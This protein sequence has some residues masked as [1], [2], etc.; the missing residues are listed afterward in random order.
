MSEFPSVQARSMQAIEQI[1]S[2]Q[3]FKARANPLVYILVSH[4]EDVTEYV[5]SYLMEHPQARTPI[6][7]NWYEIVNK[8]NDAWYLRNT[9][10]RFLFTRDLFDYQLPLDQDLYFFGRTQVVSELIDFVKKSENRGLFGLRKTGKTSILYKV[11]R[12]CNENN[13]AHVLYYDCKRYDIRSKRWIGLLG[14]ITD[15]IISVLSL[16]PAIGI[17]DGIIDR[18]IQVIRLIPP[19]KKVCVIFDEIEYISPLAKLD[20][21]WARDF[22]DFWQM[23]WSVQSEIRRISFI[24]AGVNPY[25]VELDLVDG[26]QN[27]VFGIIKHVMLTGMSLDDLGIMIRRIGRQMGLDFDDNAVGYIHSHYGGHPLLSRLACS[28]TNKKIMERT[29]ARP[30]TVD[31]TALRNSEQERDLSCSFTADILCQNLRCFTK[32]NMIC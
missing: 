5:S 19:N 21:H 28:F 29:L 9:I 26:I 30:A 7:I 8:N 17:N 6:P 10:S 32:M 25:L 2:E 12:I 3:P 11:E 31:V 16:S 1:Y 22:I 15:Q 24:V 27:P 23:L 13:I 14:L 18:F 20:V 4:A